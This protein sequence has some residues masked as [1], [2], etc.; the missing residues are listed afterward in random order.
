MIGSDLCRI[1]SSKPAV[2]QEAARDLALAI[3]D[4]LSAREEPEI[5]TVL[6]SVREAFTT[7][8]KGLNCPAVKVIEDAAPIAVALGS[9]GAREE[10]RIAR[11]RYD[12]A[13]ATSQPIVEK[14]QRQRS[15]VVGS[16]L[17]IGLISTISTIAF[18]I[19]RRP[20]RC[21]CPK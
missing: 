10:L 1:G 17:G 9:A 4:S 13:V 20:R 6:K 12:L 3:I 2:L 14:P 15:L 5:V 7:L 8:E 11:A 16:L 21:I 19:W 18:V